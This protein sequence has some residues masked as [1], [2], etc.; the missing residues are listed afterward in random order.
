MSPT[1]FNKRP[2]SED[3]SLM[4]RNGCLDSEYKSPMS[5]KG[6]RTHVTGDHRRG[7]VESGT[8]KGIPVRGTCEGG[9]R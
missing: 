8:V 3:V 1:S 7:L 2:G 9:D 6:F 5:R 4:Q